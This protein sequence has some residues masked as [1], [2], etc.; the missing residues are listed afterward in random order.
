MDAIPKDEDDQHGLPDQH[1][2]HLGEPWVFAISVGAAVRVAL[3][4]G[5]QTAPYAEGLT[6]S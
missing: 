6:Q 1:C 4:V 5:L 3:F 2:S